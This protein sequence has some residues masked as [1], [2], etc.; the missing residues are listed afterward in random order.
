MPALSNNATTAETRTASFVRMSSR[1][2]CSPFCQPWLVQMRV[3][4]NVTHLPHQQSV[5]MLAFVSI[6]EM[7]LA[8]VLPFESPNPASLNP[9]AEL[10]APDMD[11]VNSTILAR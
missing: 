7:N 3:E 9:L 10:V 1:I 4:D 5:P 2:P 8:V 11:R 6:P